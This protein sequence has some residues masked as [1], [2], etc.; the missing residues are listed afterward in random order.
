[1]KWI[2]C[3]DKMPPTGK[4]VLCF[5]E[6]GTYSLETYK[7]QDYFWAESI[8]AGIITHWILPEPPN[9]QL[10]SDDEDTQQ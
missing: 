10:I 1:M 2:K 9:E 7:K 5:N 4:E 8:D 3:S 6:E